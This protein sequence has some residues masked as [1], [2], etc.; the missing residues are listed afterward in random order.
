[1]KTH[2]QHARDAQFDKGLLLVPVERPRDPNTATTVEIQYAVD[3]SASPSRS[4]VFA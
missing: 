2:V 1:M 4:R 3:N